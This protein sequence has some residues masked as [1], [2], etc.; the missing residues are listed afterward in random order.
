MPTPV[1]LQ[2]PARKKAEL[3]HLLMACR[4]L[5]LPQLERLQ[6]A[7]AADWLDLP[8]ITYTCRPRVMQSHLEVDIEFV[9]LEEES[10]LA[11]PQ[12][13]FHLAGTGELYLWYRHDYGRSTR[14]AGPMKERWELVD[15]CGRTNGHLPDAEILRQD[16]HGRSLHDSAVEF[17]AGY[18]TKRVRAKLDEMGK[19]QYAHI[20]WGTTVQGRLPRMM[21]AIK[22]AH[23][24]GKLPNLKGADV[25]YCNCWDAYPYQLSRRTHKRLGLSYDAVSGRVVAHARATGVPASPAPTPWPR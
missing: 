20:I 16:T 14:P 18:T 23:R 25:V 9:S 19:L 2:H 1:Y 12:D 8:R 22:D 13:L 15:L 24:K 4:V 17:D 10:L 7:K 11:P 21:D 6:L 5:T 3:R